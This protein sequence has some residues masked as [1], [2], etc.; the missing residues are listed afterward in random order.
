[1]RRFG[2]DL[3]ASMKQAAAHAQGRKVP[4][5]RVTSVCRGAAAPDFAPAQSGLRPATCPSASSKYG[6]NPA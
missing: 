6:R 1:M 2:K 5:L 3:I 4:G